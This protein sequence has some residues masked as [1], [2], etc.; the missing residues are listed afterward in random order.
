MF[1]VYEYAACVLAALI[2]GTLL[3]AV[4]TMCIMLWEALPQPA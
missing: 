4:G 1:I 2:G 3:L